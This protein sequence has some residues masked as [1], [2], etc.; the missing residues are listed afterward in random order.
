MITAQL[1]VTDGHISGDDVVSVQ[2]RRI[3]VIS[4]LWFGGIT[5][6]VD[7]KPLIKLIRRIC[8]DFLPV[9]PG[10]MHIARH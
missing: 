1:P 8:T 9:I 4:G 10:E 7:H 2:I 3:S 6:L 5:L